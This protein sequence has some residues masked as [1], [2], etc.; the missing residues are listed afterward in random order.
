MPLGFRT[1]DQGCPGLSS[2][3]F[4]F[5]DS[6][7]NTVDAG[8]SLYKECGHTCP[9]GL[10]AQVVY[11][12][13]TDISGPAIRVSEDS[14]SNN[15]TLLA[16]IYIPA[17]EIIAMVRWDNQ[18]L[19]GFGTVVG[20]TVS[21]ALVPGDVLRIE[22]SIT[23]PEVYRIK[24]NDATIIQN[25][26]ET[27]VLSILNS[28]IG[29]VRIGV[30][31]VDVEPPAETE[32]EPDVL[33]IATSDVSRDSG[34][35]GTTLTDDPV[36]TVPIGANEKWHGEFFL[37]MAAESAAPDF[38]WNVTAPVGA[39]G[40]YADVPWN[41]AT[42]ALGTP[43]TTGSGLGA[44]SADVFQYRITFDVI[45]GVTPGNI[46]LQW[47]QRTSSSFDTIRKAHSSVLAFK[48]A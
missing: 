45:N 13:G 38:K 2:L 32:G 21:Q 5:D 48:Q 40:Y 36:L 31:D 28:C 12:G 34:G 23:D 4:I 11:D 22:A 30:V 24:V 27:E 44:T 9:L 43:N 20:T 6:G 17:Q 29:F 19:A 1:F 10:F 26:I 35:T 25:T 47:A 7:C 37:F 16:A 14:I 33:I 8:F 3:G 46:T 39:T 15:A 42:L 18:S 41:D